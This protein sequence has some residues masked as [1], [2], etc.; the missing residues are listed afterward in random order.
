MKVLGIIGGLG[1][2]A[3]A[4][5]LALITK[6]SN[7]A[8][9]QDHIEI[10]LHSRPQIPD[11]SA[12]IAGKSDLSPEMDLVNIGKKLA[13]D[14]AEILAIPCF[15]AHYFMEA[16]RKAAGIPVIDAIDETVS[17]LKELGIKSAGILATDGTIQKQL[18]Q[19]KLNKAGIDA[20]I[21]AAK[22]QKQVADLIYG[23]KSGHSVNVDN[24]AEISQLLFNEG[25][26]IILLGCSE[27]STLKRGPSFPVGYLDVLYVL[28]R[29]AVLECG[30]LRTQYHDLVTKSET[31]ETNLIRSSP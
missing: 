27:L 12:F 19:D 31:M 6:M 2:M 28:A 16:I 9:D 11:R 5:F 3:T 29:R 14:G 7:A 20:L 22:E 15:T 1:P 30:E 26:E 8:K 13:Q 23:I 21:P 4:H 18:Y 17:Y 24:F 25:A 10:L